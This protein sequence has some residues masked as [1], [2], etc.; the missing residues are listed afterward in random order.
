MLYFTPF[1]HPVQFFVSYDGLKFGYF[2]KRKNEESLNQQRDLKKI[3][4]FLFL[5]QF[6]CYNFTTR[7]L[8]N[9]INF[10]LESVYNVPYFQAVQY[11]VYLFPQC[12]VSTNACALRS[13]ISITLTVDRTQVGN[14]IIFYRRFCIYLKDNSAQILLLSAGLKLFDIKI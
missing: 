6:Q 2:Q 5:F 13:V 14:P 9:S 8:N 4:H 12:E 7:G 10:Y 3:K 11:I 1:I